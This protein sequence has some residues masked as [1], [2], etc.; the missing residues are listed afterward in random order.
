MS[1]ISNN[2]QPIVNSK[3]LK[4]GLFFAG[5]TATAFGGG[6][7]PIVAGLLVLQTGGAEE[8][9]D[10]AI[11]TDI[12]KDMDQEILD[13]PEII[14]H[15][16]QTITKGGLVEFD[17]GEEQIEFSKDNRVVKEHNQDVIKFDKKVIILSIV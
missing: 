12:F 8:D 4:I 1:V 11:E 16:Q 14:H 7:T 5:L 13:Y 6:V 2:K 3:N 9:V 17:T 10:K 15:I